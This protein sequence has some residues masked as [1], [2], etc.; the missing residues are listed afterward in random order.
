[1]GGDPVPGTTSREALAMLD[2]DD[3][4]R[5]VVLVGEIG[6]GMEEEAAD[7]AETMSKPV[8]AFIAGRAAPPG[9]RM[10]HAGA[11]VMGERGTYQSKRKALEAA[12]V[13]VAATPDEIG[14]LLLARLAPDF[15]K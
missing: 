9:K 14:A 7:Y 4:T 15:A 2:R 1:V 11:I 8:V 12:G 6:G 5:G 13:H 10:G 3:R